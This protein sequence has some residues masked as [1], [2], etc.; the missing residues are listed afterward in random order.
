M[1]CKPGTFVDFKST[2]MNVQ[3]YSDV[4]F[5]ISHH[6]SHMYESSCRV[7]LSNNFHQ[8]RDQFVM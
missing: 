2:R 1:L 4:Y 5:H 6:Y 3:M 7:L 8:Y